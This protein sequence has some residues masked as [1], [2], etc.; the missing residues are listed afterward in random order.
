MANDYFD[1]ISKNAPKA[2]PEDSQE[3]VNV[4]V[5]ADADCLLLCDGEYLDIQLK[6]GKMT[7]I[8]LPIGRHLLEFIYTEDANIKVEKVIDFPGK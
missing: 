5:R 6:A 2:T 4:T 7:K 8:Q 3:M 1:F